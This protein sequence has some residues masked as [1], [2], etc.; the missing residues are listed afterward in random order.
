MGVQILVML[1]TFPR[2]LVSNAQLYCFFMLRSLAN[3]QLTKLI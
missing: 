2:G 1:T 3:Q